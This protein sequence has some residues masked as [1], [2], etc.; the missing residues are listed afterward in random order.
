[1]PDVSRSCVMS[2]AVMKVSLLALVKGR[3]IIDKRMKL[4]S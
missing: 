4:E 3:K 2:V 1:M